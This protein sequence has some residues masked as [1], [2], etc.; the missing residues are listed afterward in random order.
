MNFAVHADSSD[1]TDP[2]PGCLSCQ[3]SG[4]LDLLKTVWHYV[5]TD[6]CTDLAAEMSYYF[7]MSLFPFLLV[8]AAVVGWLPSTNLWHSF[9]EWITAYLPHGS[10]QM[11]FQSVLTLTHGSAGFLSLGLLGTVW[12]ASSGFVALMD[13]LN[14]A[15]KATETRG[16]W[17]RRVIA[18]LAIAVG[19]IFLILC[20]GLVCLGQWTNAIV[21]SDLKWI[22]TF[23]VPFE[24]AGWVTTFLVLCLGLDLVNHFLPNT[25]APWRWFTAGRIFVASMFIG[26]S[27]AFNFYLRYFA[28]YSRIYGA[29]AGTIVLL[30]WIYFASLILLVG[31][32][33]DRAVQGSKA[34]ETSV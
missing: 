29:L 13:S 14:V 27:A 21:S 10:R 34:E 18:F 25:R 22:H 12:A 4:R 17:K 33:V 9:A 23:Q 11:V 5:E 8:V 2:R 20:F 26:A 32:E 30:V 3:N 15:Y 28:D 7:V 6:E 1:K 19:S 31:A 16:F 24:I